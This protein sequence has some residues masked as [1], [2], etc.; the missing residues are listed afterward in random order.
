MKTI[1]L[2]I[3]LNFLIAIILCGQN[4]PYLMINETIPNDTPII[5]GQAVISKDSIS[6]NSISFSPDGSELIYSVQT[7]GIYYMEKI[8]DN[9]TTP[10]LLEISYNSLT[11]IMYPKFS[12]DGDFIS[13]VDGNS[14]DYGFGDIYLIKRLD[15]NKWSE[16]IKLPEP[17]NSGYRDAGH[18]FAQNGNLYFTSSRVNKKGTNDIFLASPQKNGQYKVNVLSKLSIFS[19]ITDEEC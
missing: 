13:Y 9:W 6:V 12:P 5:Y 4:C 7:D 19:I 2:I 3:I 16:K 18:C 15:N 10:K 8:N 11:H 17:I 1:K 14:K